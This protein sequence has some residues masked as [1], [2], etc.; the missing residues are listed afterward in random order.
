MNERN[1]D[2]QPRPGPGR[3]PPPA[4]PPDPDHRAA[5]PGREPDA[6]AGD[7]ASTEPTEQIAELKQQI[8]GL[9]D[10]RLRALADLDNFRKR[11]AGQVSA[12]RAETRAEVAARWLPVVDNLERALDHAHADPGSIIEGIRAVLEQA[13]GVLSQLGF[14]RRDDLGNPFDPAR[15]EAIAAVSETDA[16]AG[17][18]IDVVRPAYGE[19]DRQLRPA[20]VVVARDG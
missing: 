9:E 3:S 15:H 14:P 18:V 20:Q 13:M 16:P 7:T 10:Q 2:P 12:A 5:G 11:C 6:E 17:S 19:G 8:A 4:R 1:G